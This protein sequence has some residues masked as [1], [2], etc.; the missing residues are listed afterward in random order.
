MCHSPGSYA[1]RCHIVPHARAALVVRNMLM[2]P[3]V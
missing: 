2:V 1:G 3:Q